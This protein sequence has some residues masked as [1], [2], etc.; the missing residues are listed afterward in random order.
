MPEAVCYPIEPHDF[1]FMS[2]QLKRWSH[3]FV[4]NV[5]L[6]WRGV[7][8]VPYLRSAVA[9]SMWDATLASFIYLV[10]L[11]ILTLWFQTPWLLVGYLIDAPASRCRCSSARFLAER[12]SRALASLPCV[13]RAPNCERCVF[14]CARCGSELVMGRGFHRYEKGH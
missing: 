8:R 9:V 13:L 10:L 2:K 14:P 7:L 4:Q 3:G 5:Q 12:R 11:P 1:R 6:H